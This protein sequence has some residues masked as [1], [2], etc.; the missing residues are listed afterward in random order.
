[1]SVQSGYY[2]WVC[3]IDVQ[4]GAWFGP[5]SQEEIDDYEYGFALDNNIKSWTEFTYY[6]RKPTETLTCN[7][8]KRIPP[9]GKTPPKTTTFAACALPSKLDRED[10][11]K[12]QT[13]QLQPPKVESPKTAERSSQESWFWGC[14]LGHGG[15]GECVGTNWVTTNFSGWRDTYGPYHPFDAGEYEF[16]FQI[17]LTGPDA[18][19]GRPWN[20][21]PALYIDAVY[22][23]GSDRISQWGLSWRDFVA[24][25]RN[26]TMLN[27]FTGRFRLGGPV[28]D[29]EIRTAIVYMFKASFNY[30]RVVKIV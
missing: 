11:S 8:D 12:A 30:L 24:N 1:M 17:E 3:F 15:P 27:Q 4:R 5:I 9:K 25:Q 16:Y 6:E 7:F 19:P 23:T 2:S 14:N 13:L 22:N 20:L 10:T 28:S 29:L 18:I 21:Y 26:G